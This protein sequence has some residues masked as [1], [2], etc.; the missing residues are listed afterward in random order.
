MEYALELKRLGLTNTQLTRNFKYPGKW[1]PFNHQIATT[2]FL[3]P[4]MRA[5]C[6]NDMGTGKTAA[7]IWAAEFLRAAGLVRRVMIVSLISCMK[8]VWESEL[9]GICPQR[10]T[11]VCYGDPE[12]RRAIIDNEPDYLIINP[13]GIKIVEKEL[14]LYQP[15]LIIVDEASAYKHPNTKKYKALQRIVKPETRVWLLTGTPTATAPTDVYG[16]VKLVNPH[17]MVDSFA[18][19]KNNIMI[20]I[21][22]FKWIPKSNAIETVMEYMKPAIRFSKEDCL[23]MPPVTY[24]YR[25]A[26][27]SKEQRDA[28]NNM[29]SFYRVERGQGIPITAVNA[30]AKLT[31][32]RQ[33]CMGVVYDDEHVHQYLDC[34]PRLDCLD[35]II[36]EAG[37]KCVIFVPFK[38]VMS[39][40]QK[41]LAKRFK[42]AVISGDT[43]MKARTEIFGEFQ[44]SSSLQHIIAHPATTSHGISLTRSHNSIWYGP[45]QN[46]EYYIQANNRMD[47]PGQVHPVT[48]S[49]IM[50]DPFEQKLYQALADKEH[51]QD[52]L[53]DLYSELTA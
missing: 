24:T 9:F 44:N 41:H 42:V 1:K 38:G 46:P 17:A 39:I 52:S 6:L 23:D 31:K 30:A 43:S 20:R 32:L 3:V 18:Q 19:F 37:D 8:S 27:L 7:C 21:S 34:S 28:F 5:F 13:D 14:R 4:N 47:R 11:A 26:N 2:E 48:I 45:E 15:D 10:N 53:L 12:L 16:L 40:V 36:D 25:Q 33:I 51:F 49:R 50:A 35:E 29:L 22:N